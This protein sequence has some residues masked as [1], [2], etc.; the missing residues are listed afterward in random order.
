MLRYFL[1]HFRPGQFPLQE[2]VVSEQLVRLE[3]CIRRG[4]D[5][6]SALP[7]GETALHLACHVGLP[8]Q[9]ACLLKGGANP[10]ARDHEYNTPLHLATVAWQ[11]PSTCCERQE[12]DEAA[13]LDC[14]RLLIETGVDINA[15]CSKGLQAL[16]LVTGR[17]PAILRYLLAQGADVNGADSFGDT[18]L[19][20]VF[21]QGCTELEPYQLLLDSGADPAWKNLQG[22]CLTDLFAEDEADDYM[23]GF[24]DF[25]EEY[26]R[27]RELF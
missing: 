3:N 26:R 8:L 11:L 24:S 16:H 20:H 19:H 23:G 4:F 25:A 27:I 2:A 9:V 21:W 10:H 13:R 22:K 1:Q 7:S 17:Q 6:E 5:L 15:R 12:Q 14:C 18:P